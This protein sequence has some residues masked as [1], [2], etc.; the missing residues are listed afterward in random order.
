VKSLL[1]AL[2]ILSTLSFPH[3]ALA[4][5]VH[6]FAAAGNLYTLGSIRGGMGE[7]E[8]GLI[9]PGTVGFDKLFFFREN[10]Y[11]AFGFGALSVNSWTLAFYGGFGFNY[12]LFWK[13]GL[14]GELYAVQGLN[15][16][17][18]GGALLGLSIRF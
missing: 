9:V 15:G 18:Y 2:L 6:G 4:R 16:F 3:Q 5:E 13:I 7:W 1:G 11:S 8:G 17:S 12:K 10:Y 14:R